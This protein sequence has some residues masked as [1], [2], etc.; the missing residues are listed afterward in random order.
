M[1]V[2]IRLSRDDL[3]M[4]GTAGLIRRID[5]TLKPRSDYFE[6]GDPFDRDIQGAHSEFAV[7]WWLGRPWVP[8]H[9]RPAGKPDIEPNIEVRSTKLDLAQDPHLILKRSDAP[10]RI[11]FLVLDHMPEFEIV[12]WQYGF[13]VQDPRNKRT[14]K[15]GECFMV[16]WDRLEQR[17]VVARAA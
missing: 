5:G 16:R 11:Y 1:S 2:T 14:L 7:A 6:G 12:G 13:K 4:A 9:E 15:G 3:I 10:E 8:L 17:G